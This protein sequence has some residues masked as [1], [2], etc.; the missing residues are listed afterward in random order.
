MLSHTHPLRPGD[1]LIDDHAPSCFP[2]LVRLLAPGEEY[3]PEDVPLPNI[4]F[5]GGTVRGC[6]VCARYMAVMLRADAGFQTP[7][8]FAHHVRRK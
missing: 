3:V 2:T 8:L 6:Q 5:N 7:E 1:T 4:V